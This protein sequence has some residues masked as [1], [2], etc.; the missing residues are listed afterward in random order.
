M[1]KSINRSR[2]SSHATQGGYYFDTFASGLVQNLSSAVFRCI[3]LEWGS[4]AHRLPCILSIVQLVI[5]TLSSIIMFSGDIIFRGV[6]RR[7]TYWPWFWI[8]RLFSFLTCL[9]VPVPLI[10]FSP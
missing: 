3:L 9:Q 10:C 8:V 7:R 6:E 4:V 5:Y 2:T 1:K